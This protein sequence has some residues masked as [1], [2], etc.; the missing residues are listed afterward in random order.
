MGDQVDE[1]PVVEES[2]IEEVDEAELE[3]LRNLKSYVDR[4]TPHTTTDVR[5]IADL[6]RGGLPNDRTNRVYPKAIN[7]CYTQDF[8]FKMKSF[9]PSSEPSNDIQVRFRGNHGQRLILETEDVETI[10]SIK[11]RVQDQMLDMD[12]D[13]DYPVDQQQMYFHNK[14]LED[15]RTIGHYGIKRWQ[16]INLTMKV[17]FPL[18][19]NV[20]EYEAKRDK[21]GRPVLKEEG[22]M[23]LIMT[24]AI[25]STASSYEKEAL[26]II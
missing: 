10:R 26:E 21:S 9:V 20:C 6:K 16:T 7:F 15:D 1:E 12:D 3:R 2:A 23:V 25:S 19:S 8:G 11:A 14:L 22:N 17:G 24:V 5:W 18:F 4:V 13:R